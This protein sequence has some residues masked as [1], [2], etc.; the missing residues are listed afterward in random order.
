[1]VDRRVLRIVDRVLASYAFGPDVLEGASDIL[2]SR[3]PEGRVSWPVEELDK[4]HADLPTARIGLPQ[5]SPLSDIV[6]N[7]F[8]RTVDCVVVGES[9]DGNFL[10]VRGWM[11]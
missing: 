4:L 11:I 5:G 7:W 9:L 1:M 2:T 10:Y 6:A 8:L 3:D